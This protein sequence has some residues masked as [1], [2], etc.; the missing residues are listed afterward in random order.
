MSDQ[1]QK[2][3]VTL[4]L[5]RSGS[6]LK[7]KDQT[8]EAINSWIAELRKSQ[9]DMRFSLVQFDAY[10]PDTQPFAGMAPAFP[11]SLLLTGAQGNGPLQATPVPEMHLVKTFDMLPVHEVR[12]IEADDFI[13]RGVTPLIDAAVNTIRAIES[14]TEGRE[15]IKVVLA[16]QTDGLENASVENSWETLQSLVKEK[17]A[18]GWE[19]L[20]M[21]AGINAYAQAEKMGVTRG[22][23]LSY[24]TN[25]ETTRSAFASTASKTVLYASGAAQ[26]MDYSFEEKN[27]AGDSYQ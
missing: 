1:K 7:I 6:M 22:K 24:G 18:L 12:D 17:E 25:S 8:I 3:I 26:S 13:P 10:E 23:T 14:S 16:I 27:A 19:I 5:D 4:L 15:D 9:N 21:G 11:A 20:F 2:T